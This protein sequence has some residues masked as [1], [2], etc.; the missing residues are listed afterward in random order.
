MVCPTNEYPREGSIQRTSE[1]SCSHHS[2][3]RR[4]SWELGKFL[5]FFHIVKPRRGPGYLWVGSELTSG[6]G[7]GGRRPHETEGPQPGRRTAT[8]VRGLPAPATSLPVG[9][10]GL[11]RAGQ[12]RGHCHFFPA[13]L[14]IR[15]PKGPRHDIGMECEIKSKQYSTYTSYLFLFLANFVSLNN[16]TSSINCLS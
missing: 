2:I 1:S 13:S 11:G 14:E 9:T 10:S 12:G 16:G 15:G 8:E 7:D 3:V 5:F 4:N 6:G